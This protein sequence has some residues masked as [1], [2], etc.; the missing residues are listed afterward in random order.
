MQIHHAREQVREEPRCVPE[1]GALALDAA[2]LL[3]EGER[4]DLGIGE[5]LERG[6]ASAA[7]WVEEEESVVDEAEEHGHGLFQARRR[8]GSVRVGHPRFLSLESRMAPF[9]PS[10][11][12]TD[13]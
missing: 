2:Q 6:V 9:L 4:D 12:A 3:E 11:H 10:I 1:E 13:I 5:P 8:W 7:L